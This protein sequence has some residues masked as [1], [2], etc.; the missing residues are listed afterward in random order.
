MDFATRDRYRHVIERISKGTRTSERDIARAA[1]R[2]AEEARDSGAA[3]THSHVGYF[4]IGEGV[5][6]LE[7]ETAYR[8][9]VTRRIRRAIE[10]HAGF[11]YL[12]TLTIITLMIVGVILLALIDEHDRRCLGQADVV[13]A[14]EDAGDTELDDAKPGRGQWHRREQ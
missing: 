7:R 8:P 11:S 2:M 10:Q 14:D 3:S 5:S 4:L 9:T 12:G 13:G 6:R 1:L